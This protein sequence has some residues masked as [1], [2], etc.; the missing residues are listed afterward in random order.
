MKCELDP[1]IKSM[2][3]KVGNMLFKTFKRPDGKTETRAYLMP[4]RENGKFGYERKTRVSEKEKAQRNRFSDVSHM[5]SS[6]SEEEKVRYALEWRK[7]NYRFNG[8]KYATLRGYIMA[9]LFAEKTDSK[10]SLNGVLTES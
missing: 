6:M 8:K 3:G 10:Q 4:R 2:S 5:L 7:A 1:N 9:R